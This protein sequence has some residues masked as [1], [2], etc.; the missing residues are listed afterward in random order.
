MKYLKLLLSIFICIICF[1]A[2]V[3]S[4]DI[5]LNDPDS[6]VEYII[7]LNDEI[8]NLKSE[9]SKY[10]DVSELDKDTLLILLELKSELALKLE[11]SVV[12]RDRLA[13]LEHSEI[14]LIIVRLTDE[15]DEYKQIISD[16][17]QLIGSLEELIKQQVEYTNYIMTLL[18]S[19]Q[20]YYGSSD[21]HLIN[22]NIGINLNT[23]M[24]FQLGYSYIG[25]DWFVLGGGVSMD[26]KPLEYV[27]LGFYINLGIR[28]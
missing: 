28:F 4:Q 20:D 13:E 9:I 18:D 5:D 16:A 21:S 2:V 19:Y 8:R 24:S 25:F 27:Y 10:D 17:N 7:N 1:G 6:I 26:F 22:L 15:I 3:Y 23:E 11:E 14:S 12:L